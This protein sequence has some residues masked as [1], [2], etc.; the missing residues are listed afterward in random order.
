MRRF[1]FVLCALLAVG[2]ASAQ[3]VTTSVSVAAGAAGGD[4]TGTYP[5]P[6]IASIGG[7]SVGTP[8][9]TGNVVYSASPTLSGTVAGTYTLGGTPTIANLQSLNTVAVTGTTGTGNV[10]FSN[11]PT[12]QGTTTVNVLSA[13][14]VSVI[15]NVA[16]SVGI[17]L[18]NANQLGFATGG[19]EAGFFDSTQGF[20][21][22]AQMK[23]PALT[24][25]SVAQTGTLCWT[26][27]TGAITVDTTV[28]CLAS[29]ARF[30]MDDRPLDIGLEAVLRMRPVSYDLKPEFNPAH[31]GR[32]VGLMAEEV[33]AIDER[34]IGRDGDGEIKGVRYMQ[35]TAVLVR[36]IQDQQR[37][38]D[39]L[40]RALGR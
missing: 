4:L 18:P 33:G 30:K 23:A 31:L 17:Y 6:T 29:S 13:Q 8:T 5:S 11:A 20:N 7:V 15:A 2:P 16:P 9:G 21:L 40:K 26:T 3:Q 19:V 22:I 38:I 34:L 35:L 12:F 1:V 28:A 36:A 10:V 24:Q 39:A 27:G 32:Q 14:R 37:E 25:T